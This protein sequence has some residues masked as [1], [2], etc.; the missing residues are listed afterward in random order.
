MRRS[1]SGTTTGV[2]SAD[3]DYDWVLRN[4][5]SV[6]ESIQRRVDASPAFREALR[7]EALRCIR[8]GDEETGQSLLRN[9][10]RACKPAGETESAEI[11]TSA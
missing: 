5:G 8:E 10:F 4:T 2:K 3:P 6:K 7:Q 1:N 9:Y 11:G